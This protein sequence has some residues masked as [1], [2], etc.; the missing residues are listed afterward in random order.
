MYSVINTKVLIHSSIGETLLIQTDMSRS[1]TTI[2]KTIQWHEVQLP[3]RWKLERVTTLI[4]IQ[5]IEI[6]QVAE[7][8]DGFVELV[9]NRLPRM[10][11]R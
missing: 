10:P 4:T 1:H 8:R 3:N 7:Y 5:N 11:P 2:P 6:N 9:F